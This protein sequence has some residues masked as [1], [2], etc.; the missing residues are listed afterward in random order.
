MAGEMV[1]GLA[2]HF[3]FVAIVVITELILKKKRRFIP[4]LAPALSKLTKSNMRHLCLTYL[5]RARYL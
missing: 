2:A 3:P 5:R 1:R 4:L